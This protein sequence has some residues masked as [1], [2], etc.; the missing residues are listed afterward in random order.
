MAE[1]ES[2]RTRGGMKESEK[3]LKRK[4]AAARVYFD[5]FLF[6]FVFCFNFFFI[7][8]TGCNHVII[9]VDPN[10]ITPNSNPVFSCR[11]RAGFTGRVKNCQP[12]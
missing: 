8:Q 9:G 1:G 11:V 10:P 4:D 7:N 2:E 12:Y 3:R 6:F 5:P